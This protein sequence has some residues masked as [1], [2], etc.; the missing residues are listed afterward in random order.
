MRFE[1]IDVLD[2]KSEDW[3]PAE[4]LENKQG[5]WRRREL[6]RQPKMLSS[7]HIRRWPLAGYAA[8]S[9]ARRQPCAL[10]A[11]FFLSAHRAFI[12][13]DNFFFIAGLI[14]FRAVDFLAGAEAFLGAT[15]P[16]CFAH[17]AF[18]AAEILARAEALIVKRFGLLAAI[19]LFEPAGRP[20]PRR[21]GWEPNPVRAAMACSIL[22]TSSLS[23]ATML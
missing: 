16:F 5:E 11:V 9:L 1:L 22:L 8:I 7:L 15:L 20:G 4:S 14:G 13:A 10:Y 3:I 2:V 21:E 19:A 18:C 23:C 17:R 6:N 12:M